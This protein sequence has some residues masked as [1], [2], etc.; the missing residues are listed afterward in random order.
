VDTLP[1][2]PAVATQITAINAVQGAGLASG[3][4]GQV[5]AVRGVVVGDFQAAAQLNGFFVQQVNADADAATSEGLFVFAPGARDVAL[6]DYV[7]VVGPIA[8]FTASGTGAT[9]SITQIANPTQID[10]CGQTALP[11]PVEITLPVADAAVLER[12]EGM[13]VRFTQTLAATELFE[14]GRFGQLVLAPVRQLHPNNAP[15]LPTA[16][17][18]RLGRIVLDDGSSSGNPAPTPYLSAADATGTRRMGDTVTGLT[19]VL[20]HNFGAYRL[21]PTAP[22]SF[23]VVN[24]RPDVPPAV[25]GT[26]KVASFNVLNYF[27]TLGARGANTAAEFTRQRDK[28]AAALAAMDADVVGLIEI[29]NNGDTAVTNLLDALNARVGAGTYAAVGAGRFGTDEIKV[30]IIYKP[31]KVKRIG[32]PVLPTGQILADYTAASG[33]PPLAQRF[34]TVANDGGFW[35][36]V[37][38]FKSKGSCPASGDVDQG[39]G[40]W[41][42]A[43]TVQAGALKDFA[44]TLTAGGEAD[45]LM[46]G[47][48]NSYL[49]EDPVKSL[50]AGGFESLLKRLA[51]EQRFTYVFGGETGALDHA[52]GSG[53]LRTQITGVAAWHINADEPTVLDYNLEN[54]TDDRYAPTPF[55][56]SDHDPVLVG[57]TL[58]ADPPASAATLS[59]DAPM[60]GQVG[61]AVT[62]TNLNAVASNGATFASLTVNWGDGSMP[63]SIPA[64]QTTASYTYATAGNY[65]VSAV[66]TDSA[67]ASANASRMITIAAA[68]SNALDIFFSEYVEGSSNN[69]AL[70]LY[71]PTGAAVDLSAYTVRLYSNGATTPTSSLTLTGQLAAGATYVLVHGSASATFTALANQTLP[72]GGVVNFNGDDAVVLEKSGVIIDRFGQVG[73]DPGAFWSSGGVQ[74]QDRTL[75][76]KPTARGDNQSTASFDP[77]LQWDAFA[78]DTADGLGQHSID[79]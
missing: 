34:Q 32:N 42:Q 41:N 37:N 65:T 5:V 4:V 28:I 8:E 20:S 6:G 72:G 71:N 10:V 21:H 44:A 12:Y 1:T 29:E 60:S 48:F 27:T 25:T 57:L 61:T 3:S 51:P 19:G 68:P 52:Y 30:D 24:A 7:Q 50:E 54:K 9:D 46:M 67:G 15:D 56:S 47:D 14:L 75:R 63:V 58:A 2:C 33:R 59:F 77:A 18:N 69:K 17:Q 62:L 39:Q 45:V 40:C 35:F 78:I 49:E 13:R 23:N 11:A 36:V 43:R 26:F 31:A 70:E 79:P 38:H 66:F 53:S 73:F 64:G 16:A 55:R 76:R 22:V 74:T